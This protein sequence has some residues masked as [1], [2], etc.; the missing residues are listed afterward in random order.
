MK[1]GPVGYGQASSYAAVPA[2][3]YDVAISQ[4]SDAVV[5]GKGWPVAANT[6]TSLVVIQGSSGPTLEVLDDAV[7]ATSMPS[8]GMQTGLGGTAGRSDGRLDRAAETGALAAVLAGGG[9]LLVGR[10]RRRGSEPLAAS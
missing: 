6:V 10:R 7:G 8:G 2:G 1:L 3:S 9:A 4:G 5:L